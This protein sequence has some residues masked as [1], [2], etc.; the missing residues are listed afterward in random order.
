MHEQAAEPAEPMGYQV[1]TKPLSKTKRSCEKLRVQQYSHRL[2]I[3]HLQ[4]FVTSMNTNGMEC[5]QHG[6]NESALRFLNMAKDAVNVPFEQW[7]PEE[8]ESIEPNLRN[9]LKAVTLN[10]LGCFYKSCVPF[11][12]YCCCRLLQ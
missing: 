7:T 11:R 12:C 3:D 2:T 9:K 5:L 10:N 4:E 6:E 8:V 1:R